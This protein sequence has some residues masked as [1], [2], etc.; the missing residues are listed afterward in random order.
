MHFKAVCAKWIMNLRLPCACENGL[1]LINIHVLVLNIVVLLWLFYSKSI[2]LDSDLYPPP[3]LSF[4]IEC[5]CF[6][7][8]S[9]STTKLWF[10]Y[11]WRSCFE[12]RINKA[13]RSGEVSQAAA[14]NNASAFLFIYLFIYLL[15]IMAA[16]LFLESFEQPSSVYNTVVEI[17][18]QASKFLISCRNA[19]GGSVIIKRW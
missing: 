17:V 1:K 11:F 6:S 14:I 5:S 19:P 16:H 12:K 7:F 9:I 10:Q 2:V 15:S 18:P 3:A 13:C 8:P 4:S